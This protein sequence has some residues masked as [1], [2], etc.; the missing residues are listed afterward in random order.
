MSVFRRPSPGVDR[1]RREGTREVM[2][3]AGRERLCGRLGVAKTEKLL[4]GQRLGLSLRRRLVLGDG[5]VQ[6]L[7]PALVMGIGM[8]HHR[9]IR[10]PIK[11]DVLFLET[12]PGPPLSAPDFPARQPAHLQPGGRGLADQPAADPKGLRQPADEADVVEKREIPFRDQGRVGHVDDP[13]R[14][15]ET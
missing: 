6:P 10:F 5:F 2:V 11:R 9:P 8:H 13:R 14:P 3:P 4:P 12:I 1:T 15:A 7:L